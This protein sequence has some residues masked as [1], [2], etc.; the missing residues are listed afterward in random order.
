MKMQKIVV[1]A[2]LLGTAGVSAL[3]ACSSDSTSSTSSTTSDTVTVRVTAAAGGT[4]SDPGGKATLAIPPGALEKD[5]DITLKV[6]AAANGSAGSVL[7]FGP[8]G[9]K[10][11]KPATLTVKADGVTVPDGKTV[12]VAIFENGAW[13]PLDGSKFA[14]G[15]ATAEV[16]H[17][18]MYSIVI[19]DGQVV[20]QPPASCTDVQFTP[21]GGDPTGTFKFANFC[22]DPRVLGAD[23]FKGSCNALN[24]TVDFNWD[25]TVTFTGGAASGT[26]VVAPGTQTIKATLNFP[27][28]CATNASD[29][30]VTSCAQASDGNGLNCADSTTAGSCTCTKTDTKQDTGSNNTY[31]TSGSVITITDTSD[32]ST[33]TGEYCV[34]GNLLYF[35]DTKDG[36]SGITYVLQKQ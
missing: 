3:V 20:L 23:P 5:T 12:S 18:T 34:K 19:V 15:V 21:C 11:L 33:S 8:D 9:L 6:S 10:F 30:G 32:N 7:D 35:R 36:G 22:I 26:M 1:T 25:S 16:Q 27:L 24:A 31:A 29:G 28:S 17:F 2:F 13:K 14:N 4:V